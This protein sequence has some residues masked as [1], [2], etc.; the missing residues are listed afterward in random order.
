MG[1]VIPYRITRA[2]A[3]AAA[4][5]LTACDH[6]RDPADAIES[7]REP[8]AAF[9]AEHASP[10]FRMPPETGERPAADPSSALFCADGPVA[11]SHEIGDRIEIVGRFRTIAESC[12]FLATSA[13]IDPD[14]LAAGR[15]GV[16]APYGVGTDLEGRATAERLG[17]SVFS[18]MGGFYWAPPGVATTGNTAGRGWKPGGTS[19]DEAALR[20]LASVDPDA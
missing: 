8:L 11:L 3:E 1:D 14:D 9:L 17:F 7:L 10:P 13:T 15:Y 6:N 20:A 12:D 18:S 5:I 2:L 16:D 4:G 19:L